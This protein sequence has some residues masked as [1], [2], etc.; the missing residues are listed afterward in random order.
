MWAYR[1]W[2]YLLVL[3]RN[4]LLYVYLQGE[5]NTTKFEENGAVV[6]V[7]ENR[8]IDNGARNG[9]IVISGT[10]ARLIKHLIEDR[11]PIDMTYDE[12]IIQSKLLPPIT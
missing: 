6:L 4:T 3:R 10:P 8:T 2:K 12:V 9:D 5:E 7:T 1:Y 11:S